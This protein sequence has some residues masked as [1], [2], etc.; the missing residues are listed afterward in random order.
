MNLAAIDIGTNSIHL[1]IA[2]VT[3]RGNLKV[4]IDEKEMVKL[5]VGVFATNQLSQEAFERGIAVIQRYVQLAD[6]FGVDEIITA[7]TSATRE[8]K[9]GGE[10]LDALARETGLTPHVISGKEEARLIF[11]AVRRAIAFGNEKVLVLDIG[12]GSTE[13][14]VGDQENIYF[15]KSIKLGVLRLLDMA[16]GKETLTKTDATELLGHIKLAAEEVMK[17][18]LTEGFTK[19]IGTSGTIRALGEAAHLA[20]KGSSLDTVNAEVV[21][22]KELSKLSKKLLKM[23]LEE[24]EKVPGISSNRAD[25]IHLGSMLL[26]NLLEMAQAS[27]ITLCDAS[28]REGLILDYLDSLGRKQ[29]ILGPEG[30]L[31]YRSVLHLA[32]RYQSDIEQKKHVAHLSLQLYDQLQQLHGLDDAAKE[33]LEFACMIFEVGHFIGF[34]KYHKHSRYIISNSRLRGF[35]NEEI[36]LLGHLARYHRK[37]GPKKRH[38]KFKKM[39][40]AQKYLV[41]TLSGIMR[42]AI[43][44]DKTKN[45]WVDSLSCKWTAEHIAITVKGEENPDLEIWDAMRHRF[46]LEKA[47][48]REIT[49]AAPDPVHL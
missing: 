15:K 14:T 29:T 34:P 36:T 46:V 24:R 16:G 37:S 2:E 10:F 5:G 43:G 8:A 19:V 42:I 21:S 49:I 44:L 23:T 26:V 32:L 33:L 17:E 25:A 11:L 40:K 31:R 45:Q 6:Q 28:L 3:Q 4:L 12:G 41:R 9:N 38:S 7:A 30:N 20:G 27:E 18:V 39:T 47:L 48:K 1:V 22:T 35:T 13:A